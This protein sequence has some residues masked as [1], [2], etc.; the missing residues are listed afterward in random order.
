VSDNSTTESPTVKI[1]GS[2][3]REE[4][5]DELAELRVSSSNGSAAYASL[6]FNDAA[7][8]GNT[9]A[10]GEKLEVLASGSDG[11][12]ASI[13][14]GEIA[15]IG[16]DFAAGRSA[17]SIGAY[18]AAHRLGQQ[19]E[20]TSHMNAT[21]G[22]V[23]KKIASDA[24]LTAKIDPSLGTTLEHIQQSASPLDFISQLAHVYGCEWRVEGENTLV[25]ERRQSGTPIKLTG[26]DNLRSFSVRFTA[27]EQA[28]SVEVRGWDP[29]TMQSASSTVTPSG[30][31]TLHT[32]VSAID[33][34]RKHY[35]KNRAAV[36]WPTSSSNQS[37]MDEIA[38]GVNAQMEAA[39]V[40]GRGE[41][42]VDARLRPGIQVEIGEVVPEWN[43]TYYLSGVEHVFGD[44]QPFVTRFSIGGNSPTTLV[45]LFGPR[46]SGRANSSE[47]VSHGVTVGEVTNMTDPDDLGRVK[48]RLPYLSDEHETDWARV[49]QLGAGAKR[50]FQMQPEVGDEVL[51][52]FEN[53]DLQRPYV[54]GGLWNG[55]S[56]PLNAAATTNGQVVE[57]SITSRTG[58]TLTLSEGDSDAKDFVMIRLGD[59]S[60][61]LV[62]SKEKI[63]VSAKKVPIEVSTKDA[64]M[65]LDSGKITLKSKDIV[66]DASNGIELKGMTFKL[67]A[68]TSAEVK[69]GS[70]LKLS[71]AMAE[72]SG[73]A[74]T[75]VKGGMVNIN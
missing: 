33:K 52:A 75:D 21:P 39:T 46:T 55:K 54:I 1:N 34:N 29:K 35:A 3:I 62:L 9:F 27:A 64:K 66:L 53:G 32:G 11:N 28:S 37:E 56:K 49:V 47:R 38:A 10:V 12:E 60:A 65:I 69:A 31:T 23:I 50:G 72:L 58:H 68:K 4:I 20:F 14:I 24:K 48:V 16:L 74:T 30:A 2:E 15:S 44:R 5:Y 19:S 42:S 41:V 43:G 61:T 67:D 8:V 6:R 71:G 25:V 36:A 70:Q 26:G 22:D 18:D 63:E 59:K 7:T 57:R 40:S 17:L 13:F 73:S 45:D 51:V